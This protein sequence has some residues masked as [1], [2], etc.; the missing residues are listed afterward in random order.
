MAA[1]FLYKYFGTPPKINVNDESAQ[2]DT[3]DGSQYDTRSQISRVF[4]RISSRGSF[5]DEKMDQISLYA[6]AYRTATDPTEKARIYQKSKRMY[7][8]IHH[9]EQKK[10]ALNA[11]AAAP[12]GPT[13]TVPGQPAAPDTTPTETT[14]PAATGPTLPNP[15][16]DPPTKKPETL[17]FERTTISSDLRFE[18]TLDLQLEELQRRQMEQDRLN[19]EAL[20]TT[21]RL[22]LQRQ[23]DEITLKDAVSQE[24]ILARLK[25]NIGNNK[26][27]VTR[28]I[29]KVEQNMK[30]RNIL[31]KAHEELD[32]ALTT[33]HASM[34]DLWSQPFALANEKDFIS[35]E[36]LKYETKVNQI[37]EFVTSQ[38]THLNTYFQFQCY[39][40]LR[41]F[42]HRSK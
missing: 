17:E 14:P 30:N 31:D 10:A 3:P 33:L 15:S 16:T 40:F 8:A 38:L 28:A 7:E 35:S 20:R 4:S 11:A 2:S 36:A 39:L 9:E 24:K 26:A 6:E 23:A 13:L 42:K 41:C 27:A 34:Q 37:K 12:L 32:K 5:S 29:N 25:R 22:N 21:S 19:N 1:A 18:K